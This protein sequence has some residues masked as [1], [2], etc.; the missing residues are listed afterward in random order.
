M[1]CGCQRR[2][3][4][5]FASD[6]FKFLAQPFQYLQLV[7][8]G[9]PAYL[10]EKL[11]QIRPSE[12]DVGCAFI[13]DRANGA[14]VGGLVTAA[15]AFVDDMADVQPRF[16]A[17]VVRVGLACHSATH[18]AGETVAIENIGPCFLGYFPR[19]GRLGLGTFEQVLAGLEFGAVVVGEDQVALFGAQ[20]TDAPGPFAD[21][22]GDLAQLFGFQDLAYMVQKE[23]PQFGAGTL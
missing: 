2:T 16:P 20:F 9:S 5:R 14:Q 7:C 22:S 18:L 17:G 3:L 4:C 10:D 8:R 21:A 19:K 6:I 13:A 12:R 23:L 11:L 1:K 15:Q